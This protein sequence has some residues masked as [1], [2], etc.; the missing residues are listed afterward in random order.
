MR[1]QGVAGVS[2]TQAAQASPLPVT[3]LAVPGAL[4]AWAAMPGAETEF[5]AAANTRKVVDLT[6]KTSVKIT[7]NVG[8]TGAAG[9]KVRVKYS[10]DQGSNWTDIA[11]TPEGAD[12]A[13][14]SAGI[15]AGATA[16]IATAAKTTVLV[17]IF[18]AGGNGVTSPTFAAL[19]AVFS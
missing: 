6:G 14:T 17:A 2:A 19:D 9:S 12:C 4:L 18:G 8:V 7:A 1:A 11:A 16:A 13:V 15:N 3:F 5:L 10:T